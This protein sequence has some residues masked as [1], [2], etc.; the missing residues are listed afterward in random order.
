MVSFAVLKQRVHGEKK[1]KKGK[2]MS[3]TQLS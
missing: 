3:A 1:K 2:I